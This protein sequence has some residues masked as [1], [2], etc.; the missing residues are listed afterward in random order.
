MLYPIVAALS[1]LRNWTTD[2]RHKYIGE[3]RMTS[4]GSHVDALEDECRVLDEPTE[5]DKTIMMKT[6][7]E[8]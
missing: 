4:E 3:V 6:S 5:S 2:E 7:L 1:A 8:R